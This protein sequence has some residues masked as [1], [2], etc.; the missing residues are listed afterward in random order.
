MK[1]RLKE[2]SSGSNSST[3]ADTATIASVTVGEYV[4]EPTTLMS[5]FLF[6][7]RARA[8]RRRRFSANRKTGMLTAL[9]ILVNLRL[10]KQVRPSGANTDVGV[11]Y[12]LYL[13]FVSM[14]TFSQSLAAPSSS[15]A[16]C[17][18]RSSR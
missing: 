4:A 11:A 17:K 15:D 12:R 1:V 14:L 16:G 13:F 6:R 3:W 5:F 8:S 9:V 7:I 10:G 2:A 18:D